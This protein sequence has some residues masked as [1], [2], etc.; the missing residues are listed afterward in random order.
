[1][2]CAVSGGYRSPATEAMLTI[3]SEVA[4]QYRTRRAGLALAS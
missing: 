1:V 4:E 3:L 2:A